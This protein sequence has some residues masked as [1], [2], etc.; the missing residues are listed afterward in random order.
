MKIEI[1]YFAGC[2]NHAPAVDRV[3]EVL[4]QEEVIAEL[5][6]IEITESDTAREIGFLGS[7]SVRVNGQDVEPSARAENDFGLTCRIYID[8]AQRAGLPSTE[9]IRAAVR[10]ARAV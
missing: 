6:E 4:R 5:V 1:L 8:E 10:K 7:P 2:P 9:L 3:R